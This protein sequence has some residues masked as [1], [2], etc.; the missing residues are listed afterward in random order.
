MTSSNSFVETGV[1][2]GYCILLDPHH[3]KCRDY[4]EDNDYDF[5]TSEEVRDEYQDTKRKVKSRLSQ[6]VLDHVRN[7][8]ND[9]SQGYL[10]PMD[11][12]NI[13]KRVLHHGNDAYQFLYKYYSDVVNNGIQKEELEENLR[14]IAR[15]IDRIVIQR[16]KQ[17]DSMV[18]DWTQQ[19]NHPSV[20]SALSMIHDPD[21]S[22]AVQAHDLATNNGGFTEFA[23]ANPADFIANGRKS[24]VLSNTNL[25]DIVD[26]SV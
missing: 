4:F 18:T 13:K 8:Q 7:L 22:F 23:T 17:F 26:V 16:E 12:N 3:A 15:D 10:G 5:Y 1:H 20:E 2:I 24:T 9:S 21:R 11:V 25:D 14:D 19:S 6:A